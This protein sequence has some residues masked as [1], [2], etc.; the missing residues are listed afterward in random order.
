MWNK[1]PS[2]ISPFLWVFQT[3]FGHEGLVSVID[4][5]IVVPSLLQNPEYFVLKNDPFSFELL[6]FMHHLPKELASCLIAK[7]KPKKLI[8]FRVDVSKAKYWNKKILYNLS[9]NKLFSVEFLF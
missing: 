8:G 5:S 9:T 2:F 7:K 1:I 6:M 3:L 4:P